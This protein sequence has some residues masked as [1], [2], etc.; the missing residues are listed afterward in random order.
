MLQSGQNNNVLQKP[1]VVYGLLDWGL[2]HT[3]RSIPIISHLIELNCNVLVAC[4]SDQKLVLIK[5]FPEIKYQE[6][7]GYELR[8]ATKGWLTILYIILQIPKILIKINRENR[9][10]KGFLLANKADFIVS[11]NRY[12]FY[13]SKIPSIFITHQLSIK[14]G[15]GSWA[16]KLIRFFN[17]RSIKKFTT[18]WVPDWSGKE[19]LAGP[20]SH[21]VQLP[22]VPVQWLGALSRFESCIQQ[23]QRKTDILIILSGPEPQRTL[24]EKKILDDAILISRPF[25]LVRGLPGNTDALNTPEHIKVF[26]YLPT[27][28]LNNYLCNAGNVISRSG[29]TSIMDYMKL[30]VKAIL[31]PTPGQAEQQALATHLQQSGLALCIQQNEFSLASALERA[32][33]FS[34]KIHSWDM[35][36]YK[37]VINEYIFAGKMAS[38]L[39]SLRRPKGRREL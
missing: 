33:A 35:E 2:G 6:L 12:G 19:N 22:T 3:M 8:Y 37:H 36:Q 20:L 25:V 15:L 39:A 31:I 32:A 24:L 7:E 29:Y 17:Y 34:Y 4:N 14:T 28:E 23:T 21:P 38:P 16:D 26:N 30:G 13:S 27:N 1:H 5:E 9:W 18:C 10:L 11:D